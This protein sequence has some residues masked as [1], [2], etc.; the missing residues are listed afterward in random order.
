MGEFSCC[1]T[2]IRHTNLPFLEF[3]NPSTWRNFESPQIKLCHGPHTAL[4]LLYFHVCSKHFEPFPTIL[5]SLHLFLT[6]KQLL[7]Q[8]SYYMKYIYGFALFLHW[9]RFVFSYLFFFFFVF[10]CWQLFCESG[11]KTCLA[12]LLQFISSCRVSSTA[13]LYCRCNKHGVIL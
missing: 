7:T 13:R 5:S 6:R 8:S 9:H 2:K 10:C 11:Q 3:R 1:L 12:I 4:S